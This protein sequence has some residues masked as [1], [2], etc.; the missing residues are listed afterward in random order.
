MDSTILLF[1]VQDGILNGAIYS[2]LAVAFIILFSVTRVIFV[3][4]GDFVTYA[5]LT[6]SALE[7]GQTPGSVWVLLLFGGAAAIL[8][9]VRAVRTNRSRK[10]WKI[11]SG[12]I[13]YPCLIASLLW[14]GF[15]NA[16]DILRLLLAL[17]IV[18]PLGPYIYIIFFKGLANSSI[19]N[20]LIVSVGVHWMLTG[21]GLLSFGAEGY[22]T[23]EMLHSGLEI[24]PLSIS[25]QSIAVVVLT[26]VVMLLLYA[27][28]NRSIEG[29]A[30]RATAIS[31][32][33]AGLV[34]IS[35]ENAG[36]KAFLMASSIGAVSGILISPITTLYYDSGFLIGLKGF[37]AAIIGGFASYPVAV[38]G[39]LGV[40][41]AEAFSSF[42]A[43]ALKDAIVFGLVIPVLLW[44]SLFFAHPEEE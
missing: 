24:G 18:V 28:F 32:R 44:R 2:L 35:P 23:N 41:L 22:R 1:L 10:C 11:V 38:A 43:S 31:T 36:M 27:F 40:G 30:L 42:W 26:A 6:L 15:G 14:T 39:A 7:R 3:A 37:I 34:G 19:L 29:K 16:N 17:A 33:G 20:L 9:I 21:I 12:C 4:Q 13:L 8:E 25:S 5:G